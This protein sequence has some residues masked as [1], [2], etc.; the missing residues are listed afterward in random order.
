MTLSS[1]QDLFAEELR[2][3]YDAEHQIIDALPKMIEAASSADLKAAL[4][5]HLKLTEGHVDRLE[6]VFKARGVEAKRKKCD[7]MAGLLAEGQKVLEADMTPE[8][9]DA[10]LISAAQRVEHYEIAVYGALRTYAQQLADLESARLLQT[11]LD[12]EA[13]ADR[14][15]SQLAE[16]SVNLLAAD[17]EPVSR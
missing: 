17:T 10:A 12:Q 3:L 7:G 6:E 4:N 2:D 16:F 5:R 13:D 15:L 9:R 11:T 14:S 8:V 1:L